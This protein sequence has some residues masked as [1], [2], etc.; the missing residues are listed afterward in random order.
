MIVKVYIC[1]FIA[2]CVI[3]LLRTSKSKMTF[4]V[5]AVCSIS[6]LIAALSFFEKIISTLKYVGSDVKGINTFLYIPLIIVACEYLCSICQDIGEKSLAEAISVFTKTAV[7]AASLKML[8]N[9]ID[10]IK[11]LT[12]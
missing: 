11:G 2:I 10:I 5:S 9:V 4:S 8:S 12:G 7:I 1:A 3:L 6:I